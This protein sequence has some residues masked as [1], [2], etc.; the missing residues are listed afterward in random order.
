MKHLLLFTL[1]FA[2]SL[3]AVAQKPEA[4][5]TPAQAT[6]LPPGTL[7]EAQQLKVTQVEV[8]FL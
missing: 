6:A 1:I 4:A 3:I 5:P 2:V 7:T 8:Q